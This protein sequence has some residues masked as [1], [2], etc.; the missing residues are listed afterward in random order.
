MLDADQTPRTLCRSANK[1]GLKRH[2]L[3]YLG[4]LVKCDGSRTRTDDSTGL[5]LRSVN[6]M[7]AAKLS[8]PTICYL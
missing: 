6:M 4:A 5:L 2:Q 8:N 1:T 3:R 7:S